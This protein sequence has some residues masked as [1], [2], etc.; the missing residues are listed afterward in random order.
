MRNVAIAGVGFSKHVSKR[1]DVNIAELV[2]EAVRPVFEDTGLS[3]GD[4]DACVT[5]NMPGFE[6]I[7]SPELWGSGQWGGLGKPALRITTGGTTGSSV[8][9]GAFYMVASGLYD[10]VLTLA[11]EKQSDGDTTMG[12][13]SVALADAASQFAYGVE[14]LPFLGALGGAIGLFV[15]QAASYMHKTGCTIDH[16]DRAAAM[17]RNNAVR[18]PYSHLKQEGV[19]AE[20]IAATRM[21][22][23]PLRYGHTCPATD[24]ACAMIFTTEDRAKAITDRPAWIKGVA[25]CSEEPAALGLFGGGSVNLVLDDQRSCTFA[26]NKAYKMAGISDP[27]AEIDMAE[28]YVPFAHLFFIYFERLLLCGQGEAPRLFDGG[29]MGIGGDLPNCPSGAVMSTNAIGASAMERIAEC[30]LQIMGKAGEHQVEK[31]VHHAV[32]HGLGGAANFN[33]VTV[34]GDRP[35]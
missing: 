19:T 3:P 23:Y 34:L 20:D 15:Y 9:H 32:A 18:N 7:N 2:Y 29:V 11:F 22:S 14:M 25:A 12:L 27:A 8:A 5:G 16:F 10:T 33:V 26:A 24:G 1:R 30:A 28:P 6:G 17:L 35:N 21:I 13:N 31:E 4:I